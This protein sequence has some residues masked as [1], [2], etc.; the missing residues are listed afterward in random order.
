VSARILTTVVWL[1]AGHAVL[2]GLYWLLLQTPESNVWMLGA[3]LAVVLAAAWLT[4]IVEMTALLTAGSGGSVRSSAGASI[5]RAWLVVLPLG[6]FAA[7]WW[8]AG[9]AAD[10]HARH[11]GQIDAWIIAKTGWTRTAR[12]HEGLAWLLAFVRYGVGTSL[13]VALTGAL[14]T[15]GPRGLASRWIAGGLAWKPLAVT[16]LAL[17]AGIWFPW[18]AVYWRPASLPPTWVQPAFAALKLLAL[19]VVGNLAWAV[20]LRTASRQP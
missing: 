1:C 15:G 3:S 11:S 19:Y 17:L 8:L 14:A 12:L 4:G 7:V 2:A 5:R 20:V 9:T 6:L 18:Q 13:A 10:A 16:S